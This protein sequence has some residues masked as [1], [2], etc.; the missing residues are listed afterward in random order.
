MTYQKLLGFDNLYEIDTEYPYK[1][2][3]IKTNRILSE[4]VSKTG[5]ITVHLNQHTY[6]K[7]SASNL[8]I[9]L[10]YSFQENYKHPF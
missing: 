2:R 1:I 5:Y 7:H 3:N 9:K 8:T 10:H 4:S 6:N